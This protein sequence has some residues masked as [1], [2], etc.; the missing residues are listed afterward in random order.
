M[1]GRERMARCKSC[2]KSG[3]F[4][5]VDGLGLCAS[6]VVSVRPTI[7]FQVNRA[8]ESTHAVDTRKTPLARLQAVER[9]RGACSYLLAF[10]RKG[11]FILTP[12]ARELLENL[13]VIG[14]QIADDAILTHSSEAREKAIDA[15]SE[16]AKLTGYAVAIKA[17]LKLSTVAHDPSVLEEAALALR[18]ERDRLRFDLTC[19]KA[20]AAVAKGQTKKAIDLF[21]QAIV[22]L[23]HDSTP[24]DKQMDLI[25]KAEDRI[26]ALGGTPP[27]HGQQTGPP[28][29]PG[30]R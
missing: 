2:D 28:R 26:I 18:M 17:L 14:R 13:T 9:A 19:R 4:L 25:Y 20:Q 3:F 29:L 10:E 21:I 1:K 30:A 24:D 12:S 7:E 15:P 23:Q 5:T 22:D 11:I 8:V 16:S 6:C 27:T